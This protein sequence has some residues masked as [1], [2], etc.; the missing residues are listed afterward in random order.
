MTKSQREEAKLTDYRQFSTVAP[1]R[2]GT[3]ADFASAAQLLR[4]ASFDE[5]TICEAFGLEDI[6]ELG[7]LTVADVAR[8]DIAQQLSV[9]IRLFV[10]LIFVPRADVEQAFDPD[11]LGPLI[12]LGLLCHDES[13]DN[14]YSPVFLYPVD[15]FLIAS[16]RLTNADGSSN[17]DLTDIVFPAIT[18]GTLQFLRTLPV[19]RNGETLDLCSGTGVGAFALSRTAKRAC[20]VDI[21]ARAADYARFNKALNGC[22]NV[23]VRPGDLY[24][25]VSEQTFDGIVAHPPYVPSVSIETIWRDGGSIGDSFIERIVAALPRYL[26]VGGFA[27]ILAQGVD[28]REGK[29]EERA[30]RWLGESAPEFDIVF[31]SEKERGP[32]KVLELLGKRSSA[33][34]IQTLGEAFKA[35]EVVNMPYGALFMRRVNRLGEDQPWTIRAKLSPETTG[36][37]FQSVFS[38]HDHLSR[39]SF[40]TT[41]PTTKPRL[42]PHLEVH[43]TH[44]VHED[45]LVP[46]EYIFATSRPFAKRVRIDAWALPLFL[47]FNGESTV[48]EVY[49]AGRADSE[50]PPQFG[51]SDFIVLITRSIETGFLILPDNE[52]KVSWAR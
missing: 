25:A 33:E 52:C 17:A 30:R 7:R 31:A 45:S 20:A 22:D 16:D 44:V 40:K 39:S 2:I 34:V 48:A 43:V 28:T 23:E 47:R 26:R 19:I 13:A 36:A 1:V 42:A 29:F 10:L 50:M 49:D 4:K 46:A 21:T 9:L 11:S 5:R 3:P 32:Q 51:L 12:A 14:L 35:A 41:L 8:A 37:D 15:G 27:V 24:E 18:Q 6:S 38:L